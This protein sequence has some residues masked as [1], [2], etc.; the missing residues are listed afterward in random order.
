LVPNT[1]PV[2]GFHVYTPSA[3][4]ASRPDSLRALA[5]T[6]A[7]AL[8]AEQFAEG[9]MFAL[10]PVALQCQAARVSA[11]QRVWKIAGRG[12]VSSLDARDLLRRLMVGLWVQDS[13]VSSA[14]RPLLPWPSDLSLRPPSFKELLYTVCTQVEVAV[15]ER[16]VR[17]YRG[18][19]LI[20]THARLFAPRSRP[21]LCGWG[22]AIGIE[23]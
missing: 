2:R 5:E 1:A 23:Q 21:T 19:E 13:Q 14:P 6:I 9:E 17:I 12:R 11:T 20:A 3:A 15:G 16:A 22:A 10:L 18:S 8:M 4:D 7:R